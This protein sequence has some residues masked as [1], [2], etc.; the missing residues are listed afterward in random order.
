L[1]SDE[2]CRAMGRAGQA[3][4]RELFDLDRSADRLAALLLQ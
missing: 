3:R 1:E 4:V 2:L